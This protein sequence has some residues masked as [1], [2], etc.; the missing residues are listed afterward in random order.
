MGVQ[1]TRNLNGNDYYRIGLAHVENNGITIAIVYSI[2]NLRNTGITDCIMQFAIPEFLFFIVHKIWTFSSKKKFV[3]T[4]RSSFVYSIDLWN[5]ELHS[6]LFSVV[7]LAEAIMQ[8][9]RADPHVIRASLVSMD[10]A[11]VINV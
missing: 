9:S 3:K 11:R 8:K 5:I 4:S 1:Q 10:R 6:I 7:D 2:Q